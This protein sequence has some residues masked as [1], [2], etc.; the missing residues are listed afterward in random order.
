MKVALPLRA[1]DAFCE[2]VSSLK[3]GASQPASQPATEKNQNLIKSASDN[4][5]SRGS[6]L[7]RG[8]LV[9]ANSNRLERVGKETTNYRSRSLGFILGDCSRECRGRACCSL[10]HRTTASANQWDRKR[11]FLFERWRR[12]SP[13]TIERLDRDQCQDYEGRRRSSRFSK[14]ANKRQ[15]RPPAVLG[16]AHFW[17]RIRFCAL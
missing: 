16:S 1:S 8:R 13:V 5:K 14:R 17:S 2:V 11:T 4:D 12:C 10:L 3:A 6:R 9:C 7:A 15:Q